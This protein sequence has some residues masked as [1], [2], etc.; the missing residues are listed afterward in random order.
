M[1]KPM[2]KASESDLD[3][4]QAKILEAI[5]EKFV[6]LQKALR[7]DNSRPNSDDDTSGK[8]LLERFQAV[9]SKPSDSG[10]VTDKEIGNRLLER[11]R[12]VGQDK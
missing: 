5:G 2:Y 4:E 1:I 9:Q 12:A 3:T 8:T 7:E 10:K 11:L 6:P